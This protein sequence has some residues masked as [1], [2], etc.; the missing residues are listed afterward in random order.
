MRTG[1][2]SAI[3]EPKTSWRVAYR[4]SRQCR[5]LESPKCPPETLVCTLSRSRRRHARP[6]APAA[7]L[8][9]RQYKRL[10][11]ALRRR[12]SVPL[13]PVH[14]NRVAVRGKSCICHWRTSLSK[15]LLRADLPTLVVDVRTPQNFVF[16]W[17]MTPTS[18]REPIS[19][20]RV[21]EPPL[22]Q[23]SPCRH[24]HTESSSVHG[25]D[26]RISSRQPP[27]ARP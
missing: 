7:C 19:N 15:A 26:W 25:P 5:P 21:Y 18:R 14:S 10:T 17:A 16:A 13:C 4:A 27:L 2:P 11:L 9:R 23:Y 20:R 1:E 8:Q 6:Q 3:N 12:Q 22:L 24:T